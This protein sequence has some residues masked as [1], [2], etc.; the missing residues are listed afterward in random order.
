MNNGF[1]K[2]KFTRT[3]IFAVISA[4]GILTLLLLN[5]GLTYLG[6][7]RMLFADM[8][9]EGFYT[10]TDN[11]LETCHAI[12]DNIE[13][14]DAD[15]N[16]K[17]VVITFCNDPDRLIGNIDTRYTYYLALTLR[18]LFDNVEVKTVNVT[19]NPTAV[20]QYKTTSRDAIQP[21]D[22]IFSYG[23][24]YRIA[25]AK[26]FWTSDYFSYNGEYKMATILSS[27]TAINQPAAYFTTDHGETYYNPLDPDAAG[28]RDAAQLADLLTERGLQIKNINL[29][30]VDRVPED[31]AL[32]IINNPTADFTYD[33]DKLDSFGYVTDTE[34]LDRYLVS[35]Q[36]AIIVNKAWDV[37]LPTLEAFLFEWGIGFGNSLVFDDGNCLPDVGTEGTAI[38]GVYDE[39]TLGG[40]YY[41]N[42]AGLSSAPRMVFT[43]SG[44]VYNAVID[45]DAVGE[46]GC[47]NAERT[48]SDYIY[49]SEGAVAY[50][51]LDKN[52]ITSDASKKAL[53]AMTVRSELDS[54]TGERVYSYLFCSNTGDFFSE[55]LLG[56]PSYANY[57]VAAAMI[58]NIS[59]TDRYASLELGGTSPNSPSYGGKQTLSTKMSETPSTVYGSDGSKLKENAGLTSADKGVFTVIVAAVPVT[60]FILGAV[61]FVRRRFM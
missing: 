60:A 6:S 25:A 51:D 31:C 46:M 55:A 2:G 27:L 36:G 40:A 39:N 44:Y 56:N 50:T 3:K 22:I 8:T 11:M 33:E 61:C 45:S 59:R 30:E 17:N 48:Y 42:Y 1:F 21:T 58:D 52:V 49:T 18:N 47:Y 28:N 20:A 41:L 7:E 38:L 43:N 57:D 12:L 16:E 14:T 34:K 53:A 5:L 13:K 23:G 24:R 54:F 19:L 10:A 9:P 32:L 4:V 37:S 29:S 15:G 26:T 35:H